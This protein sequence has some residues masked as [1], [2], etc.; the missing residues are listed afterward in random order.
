MSL[1]LALHA[2][3]Y[4][5]LASDTRRTCYNAAGEVTRVVDG[6][7]KTWTSERTIISGTG[8]S[9]LLDAVGRR[10]T[11]E[12]LGSLDEVLA[13]IGQERRRAVLSA[14]HEYSREHAALK[15][16]WFF[17]AR[18]PL[19]DGGHE[20]VL[21]SYYA[22]AGHHLTLHGAGS[23]APLVP[24]DNDSD[25]G[26]RAVVTRFMQACR[27]CAA[28]AD[29]ESSI[30]YNAQCM[31]TIIAAAA[32]VFSTVSAE[33]VV[34]IHTIEGTVRE[35]GADEYMPAVDGESAITENG[36]V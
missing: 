16:N 1:V 18:L 8:Y 28:G 22:G 23:V 13:I 21:V 24:D 34:V 5:M 2:G 10:V 27:V 14:P 4:I 32:G 36:Q 11:E 29:L 35:L 15:T 12:P 19:E 20:L 7:R 31:R 26:P 3:R 17:S 6:D 25:E 33:S 9:P 30:A